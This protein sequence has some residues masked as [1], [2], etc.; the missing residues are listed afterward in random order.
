MKVSPIEEF[1]GLYSIRNR[2]GG[3]RDVRMQS[4]H[5]AVKMKTQKEGRTEQ[6]LCRI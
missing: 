4:V 5:P 1:E 3:L 6:N 2:V